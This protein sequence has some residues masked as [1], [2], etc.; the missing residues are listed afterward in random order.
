MSSGSR[1]RAPDRIC[2]PTTEGREAKQQERKT[3]LLAES[4]DVAVIDSLS[5]RLH[6]SVDS[7]AVLGYS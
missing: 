1:G 3:L 4:F 2:M 5:I 7:S 6:K